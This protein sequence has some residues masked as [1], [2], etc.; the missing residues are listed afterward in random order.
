MRARI[1]S[2]LYR[3]PIVGIVIALAI[4]IAL[5]GIFVFAGNKSVA[6][7]SA[8]EPSGSMAQVPPPQ[9][10]QEPPLPEITPSRTPV[11]ATPV[12]A[13][14][15]PALPITHTTSTA[16]IETDALQPAQSGFNAQV[17]IHT[18][19]WAPTGDKLLFVTT[20]G[21]LYWS[22][23]DGTNATLLHQYEP[24][25]IWRLLEDQRP[26]ANTILIP[27]AGAP[28]ANGIGREP[29]HMDVVRFTP[30]QPP[31]FEEV[32]EDKAIWH[33]RWWRPDRASGVEPGPYI[34]L[35]RLVTL[36]ANGHIVAVRNVPYMI[37]GAVKP[38]GEWLAY[39][40][41]QQTTDTPFYGSNPA[42]VY[43]LNLNTGQRM[44]VTA[45]G[46]GNGVPGGVHS[47]S[48]DGNW[49][50]MAATIDGALRG[51]LV[52]ADGSEWV[53]VTP[54]GYSGLDA[55]WSPDS[56]KLAYSLQAG[57]R[58]DP[59]HQAVPVT[60]QL[61]VVD[62]PTR[63]V[64]ASADPGPIAGQSTAPSM[65]QPVWSPDGSTLALLSF[66]PECSPL[67]AAQNPALYMM[68]FLK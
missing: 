9:T 63:K 49:F 51:V 13:V 3:R 38:G 47:W 48:P 42:T 26:M 4:I 41:S 62:V 43:L 15:E 23:I 34:G 39:I 29:G 65:M 61:Y 33:I 55:A 5:K 56:R 46:Q 53:I 20:S 14:L 31:T 28:S 66:D 16:A 59:D 21:R 19:T 25:T 11:P 2:A 54:P 45:S 32:H 68:S 52:S 18:L 7:I 50:L 36:D 30:G 35:D 27:H 67:C 37:A 60:S 1:K 10:T 58:E 44:Q 40:T 17:P 24:D 57:G 12:P 6:D 22:N 8:P 64:T